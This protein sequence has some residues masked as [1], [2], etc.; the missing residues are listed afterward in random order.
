MCRWWLLFPSSFCNTGHRMSQTGRTHEEKSRSTW[1]QTGFGVLCSIALL[2]SNCFSLENIKRIQGLEL[3][4]AQMP[5]GSE[6][7]TSGRYGTACCSEADSCLRKESVESLWVLILYDA[8]DS[9]R[10]APPKQLRGCPKMRECS[11]ANMA[12]V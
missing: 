6:N 12:R 5:Q 8:R 2:T 10:R 9:N 7:F 3:C 1:A 4:C 11:E